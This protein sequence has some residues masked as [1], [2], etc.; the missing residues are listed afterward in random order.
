[1][2]AIYNVLTWFWTLILFL[3]NL[4]IFSHPYLIH[5]MSKFGIFIPLDLVQ[6]YLYIYL[7]FYL[8]KEIVLLSNFEKLPWNKKH[9]N[10][11]P[12]RIFKIYTN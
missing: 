10:V 11:P 9:L 5:M 1:L 12:S 7:L 6:N 2:L 3:L 4:V 8:V